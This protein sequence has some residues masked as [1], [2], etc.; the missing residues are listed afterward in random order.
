MYGRQVSWLPL[1]EFCCP[2]HPFLNILNLPLVLT[3]HKNSEEVKQ[4][5]LK[6]V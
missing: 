5:Y 6:H 1:S 3:W 2:S 4:V